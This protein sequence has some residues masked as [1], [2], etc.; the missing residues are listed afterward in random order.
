MSRGDR[1][2]EPIAVAVRSKLPLSAPGPS[3]RPNRVIDL[4]TRASALRGG[5][6]PEPDG[7]LVA[8]LRAGRPDASTV[9]F[10]RYGGDVERVLY[11]ILGPDPEIK[12]LLQDVF[13]AALGSLDKLRDPDAL[14]GWLTSIAVRKARKCILKRQRWRFIQLWP[15]SELPEREA[16]AA[17]PEVSEALR[18]TYA[19]L[20]CMP[21]DERVAFALR[22]VAGMELTVVAAACEV[23]LATIKRRLGRA[24]ATFAALASQQPALREWLEPAASASPPDDGGAS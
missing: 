20:A 6:S 17:S 7:A 9:L 11:R 10:D 21:A 2:R 4:P 15:G 1:D 3:S 24:Q 8:A 13:V 16:L 18:C 14:R 19:V 5:A 12:D 22:F 23:S